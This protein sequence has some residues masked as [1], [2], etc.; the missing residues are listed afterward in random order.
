MLIFRFP[1]DPCAGR[2]ETNGGASSTTFA[3]NAWRMNRGAH[4]GAMH[5][6][7]SSGAGEKEAT[8]QV[9]A[10]ANGLLVTLSRSLPIM[11]SE[12]CGPCAL[13]CSTDK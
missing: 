8:P 4:A 5:M 13:K 11:Q 3:S 7:I 6:H 2:A 1:S 10:Q 9:P 12:E